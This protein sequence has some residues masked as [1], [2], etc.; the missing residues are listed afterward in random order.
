MAISPAILA[1]EEVSAVT[2]RPGTPPPPRTPD[3][4]LRGPQSR[5][6]APALL[7]FLR[8]RRQL[9]DPEEACGQVGTSLGERHLLADVEFSFLT[10]RWNR[11]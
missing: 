9:H 5:G 3:V 1:P 6:L 8:P 2:L 11:K 10:L 4:S 7:L